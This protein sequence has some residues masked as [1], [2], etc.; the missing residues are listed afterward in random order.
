VL[1]TKVLG[2]DID[3]KYLDFQARVKKR[4]HENL[5]TLDTAKLISQHPKLKQHE[6]TLIEIGVLAKEYRISTDEI[7][8]YTLPEFFSNAP[9]SIYENLKSHLIS[10]FFIGKEKPDLSKPVL[11][12]KKTLINELNFNFSPANQLF[13]SGISINFLNEKD[14]YHYILPTFFKHAPTKIYSNLD[15]YLNTIY[16]F[17]EAIISNEIGLTRFQETVWPTLIKHLPEK[18]FERLEY[19]L[20]LIQELVLQYAKKVS[21]HEK[22]NIVEH[23]YQTIL[24]IFLESCP[25]EIYDDFDKF[26]TILYRLGIVILESDVKTN[27]QYL[28]HVSWFLH[29]APKEIYVDN[30][31]NYFKPKNNEEILFLF[32]LLSDHSLL[33]KHQLIRWEN[34]RS[35]QSMHEEMVRA[36]NGLFDGGITPAGFKKYK[37]G[38]LS[39]DLIKKINAKQKVTALLYKKFKNF[40]KQFEINNET[41]FMIAAISL[42]SHANKILEDKN[43]SYIFSI[44]KKHG[45]I[46]NYYRYQKNSVLLELEKTGF[47]TGYLLSDQVVHQASPS[48]I[49]HSSLSES[50]EERFKTLIQRLLGSK[51]NPPKNIF[52]FNG[53]NAKRFKLYSKIAPD[54]QPALGGDREAAERVID[55]FLDLLSIEKLKIKKTQ[56]T[57]PKKRIL[58][59][60]HDLFSGLKGEIGQQKIVLSK[61]LKAVRSQFRIPEILFD[62]QRLSCC[63]FKPHGEMNGEIS[64]IILDPKTPLLEIWIEGEPDFMGVATQYLGVNRSGEPVVFI[65]TFEANHSIFSFGK[66]YGQQFVLDA[67]VKDARG[68]NAK[69]VII[70]ECEYG[71]PLEFVNFVKNISKKNGFKDSITSEKDYYYKV[72]DS[73]DVGLEDSKMNRKHY[74]DAFGDGLPLIGTIPC[75]VIDVEKYLLH[76]KFDQEIAD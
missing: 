33:Y 15:Q 31:E 41:G 53:Q 37:V 16:R 42:L 6:E 13:I 74:T 43:V 59:E 39:R 63:I 25:E 29:T 26:H 52:E 61:S 36:L 22:F 55:F 11:L 3:E 47:N 57:F 62:N 71:K 35:A 14:L 65:D 10:I 28:H 66:N 23:F 1:T 30:F 27:F 72:A 32:S 34:A 45:T 2:K 68:L 12:T 56:N 51:E 9:D 21:P 67:L 73:W 49:N 20:N 76:R 40:P 44:I 70:F 69:E 38:Y 8:D 24:P 19:Y 48:G 18:L 17:F 75:L 64:L 54:Y 46:A 50:F 5:I 58:E 7:F 60:Y 4:T